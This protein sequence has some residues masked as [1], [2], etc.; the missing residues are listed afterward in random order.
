M[1]INFTCE[2]VGYLMNNS[3]VMML[4]RAKMLNWHGKQKQ[5]VPVTLNDLYLVEERTKTIMR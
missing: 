3:Y 4:L 1:R 5:N 2:K